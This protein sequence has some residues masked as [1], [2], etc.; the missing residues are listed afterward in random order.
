MR[1]LYIVG[2][3][4]INL[5]DNA[6]YTRHITECV[7]AMEELGHDVRLLMSGGEKTSGQK[8]TFRKVKKFIP[9]FASAMLKDATR[10]MYDVRFRDR[11][12]R[13]L[14]EYQ[15]DFIYNRHALF[16]TAGMIAGK[17]LGI[18]TILEVNARIVS[19]AQRYFR[20]GLK[21]IANRSERV[22]FAAAGA[23]I[24][25]S[26]QLRDELI[27]TG[28]PAKKVHVN[29]NGVNP[30][31]FR[32]SIDCSSV[33][34][35]YRLD[36]RL[37]IGFV[38][39]LA[40]WL[41]VPNLLEA[42]YVICQKRPDVV[43]LV[44]G[45]GDEYEYLRKKIKEYQIEDKFLLVG[46]ISHEEV[47][48]YVAAM[49]IATAPYSRKEHTYNSSIKLFEYMAAGKAIIVSNLG[50]MGEV[51]DDGNTGLLVETGSVA[52]LTEKLLFLIER[53]ELRKEMGAKAREIVL[54]NYT[55]QRNA[56][57]IIALYRELCAGNKVEST[58]L[59]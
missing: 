23:I 54:E 32:P 15:P 22:A 9:S 33:E 13:T 5:A 38:G 17:K 7:H 36:G 58:C 56:E 29:P 6:G 45:W 14:Q 26:T 57:R 59:Q 41:G 3:P 34:K 44:V 49:D 4:S 11:I 8:A 50:Q 16:H 25:V 35:K 21:A 52:D 39:S 20:V 10:I 27:K 1:I 42:A 48:V 2:D 30:E 53:P 12:E 40:T 18:P 43:F 28:V 47:P 51:I 31:Q 46:A 55:W 24:V 19:E 37:V